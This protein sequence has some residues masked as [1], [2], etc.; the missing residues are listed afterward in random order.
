LKMHRARF[1]ASPCTV[2]YGASLRMTVSKSFSAACEAPTFQTR[3]D[4][5]GLAER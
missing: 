5:C 2:R 1:F 4:K 3:G